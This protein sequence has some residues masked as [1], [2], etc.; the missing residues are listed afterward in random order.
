MPEQYHCFIVFYQ[1]ALCS[2]TDLQFWFYHTQIEIRSV[3]EGQAWEFC[4]YQL[5]FHE[6]KDA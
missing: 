4:F 2:E 1:K 6:K 3:L 5:M